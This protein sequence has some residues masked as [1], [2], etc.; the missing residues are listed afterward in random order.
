MRLKDEIEK[1]FTLQKI[2]TQILKFQNKILQLQSDSEVMRKHKVLMEKK[3]KVNE[4]LEPHKK[5]IKNM[6]YDLQKYQQKQK[7]V[8]D[9]LFSGTIADSKELQTLQREREQYASLQKKLEDKILKIMLGTNEVENERL[10]IEDEIKSIEVIIKKEQ[11]SHESEIESI[12]KEITKLEE[13][14]N[15]YR[16]KITPKI[17]QIYDDLYKRKDG[18]VITEVNDGFCGGC[19]IAVPVAIY[20]KAK[21]GEEIVNCEVCKRILYFSD[22]KI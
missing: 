22:N 19:F 1:L 12:K 18:L 8:E 16:N 7:E 14:R 6:Q 21:E 10:K 2:D 5:E 17:L 4:E 13:K 15:N 11:E 9:K 20:E 3:K